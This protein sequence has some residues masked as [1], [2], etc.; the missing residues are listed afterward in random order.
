M[1]RTVV[2]V[3]ALVCTLFV[4]ACQD[5]QPAERESRNL[6]ETLLNAPVS[7]FEP[8][9][10]E[11][12]S[13]IP[14]ELL[15]FD[16][17]AVDAPLVMIEMS[18]YGCGYCRQFHM[19]TFPVIL[20]EFIASGKVAWKFMPFVTGMFDNSLVATM[21]AECTLAQS[22]ELFVVMSERLWA[23]QAEWKRGDDPEG[24]TRGWAQE[25][26]ADMTAFDQ[27]VSQEERLDRI[28]SATGVA[29]QLGIRGTPTFLIPGYPPIQ[30]ALP[31]ETFKEVLNMLHEELTAKAEPR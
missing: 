19:E 5:E 17:G 29:G 20:E 24:L 13:P 25:L 12:E 8:P 14:L 9:P 21:A 4:T 6:T 7:Q 26:G 22:D 10:R 30:G 3:A 15:G 27:C 18:D 23:D 28:A 16:L 11:L 2:G 1:K 31:T